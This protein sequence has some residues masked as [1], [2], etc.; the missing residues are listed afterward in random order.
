LVQTPGGGAGADGEQDG[1]ESE[2]SCRNLVADWVMIGSG[3]E[4]GQSQWS[5]WA[6][7]VAD[8]VD[9]YCGTLSEE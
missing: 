4:Q 9:C 7:T 5:G 6:D 1:D 8:Y 2:D 3:G